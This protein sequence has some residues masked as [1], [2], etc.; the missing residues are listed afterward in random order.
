MAR[1]LHRHAPLERRVIAR[2]K[3]LYGELY[4]LTATEQSFDVR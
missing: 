4:S 1:P 2:K 3:Q